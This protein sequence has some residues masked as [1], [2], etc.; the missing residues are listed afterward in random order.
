MSFLES[1]KPLIGLRSSKITAAATTEPASGP[2]PA[3][4]TPATSPGAS[5][6][7]A[8]CSVSKGADFLVRFL[9]ED[10]AGGLTGED[11][12]DGISGQFRCVALEIGVQR[13]KALL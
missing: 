11:L 5:H 7:S 1:F 4:S 2:R 12:G 10:L 13:G 9:A 6:E 8:A 3:S